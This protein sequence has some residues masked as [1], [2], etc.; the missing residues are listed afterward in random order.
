MINYSAYK[1]L[2][3]QGYSPKNAKFMLEK[4]PPETFVDYDGETSYQFDFQNFRINV[5]VALSPYQ[6]S[7]DWS[8]HFS[9]QWKPGAIKLDPR[10][11]EAPWFIPENPE[12]ET[13]EYYIENKYSRT[14]SRENARK[15][16]IEDR[17]R[18]LSQGEY[19]DEYAVSVDIICPVTG[20][21]L[22]SEALHGICLDGDYKKQE[23]N[24]LYI[25]EIIGDLL[26]TA[27]MEAQKQVTLIINT[28]Q[29]TLQEA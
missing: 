13:Y 2:R 21:T 14:L 18:A 23:T 27:I 26:R 25:N 8:G 9:A 28:Y 15:Q 10:K 1:T 16:V 7:S 11:C 29:K 17:D 6:D 19:W 22:G 20:I 12:K 24:N 4:E 5:T 3:E